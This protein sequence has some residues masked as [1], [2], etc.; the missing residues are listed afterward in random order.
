MNGAGGAFGGKLTRATHV[1][2]AAALGAVRLRRPC[3]MTLDLQQ[4]MQMTGGRE[5]CSCCLDAI[6]AV[7]T[8]FER[9]FNTPVY[10]QLSES[11]F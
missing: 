9:G 3:R 2:A 1:A 6:Y 7:W 8:P 5:A 10:T 4:D 11:R